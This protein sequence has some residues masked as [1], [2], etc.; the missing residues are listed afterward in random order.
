MS[1]AGVEQRSLRAGRL[2]PRSSTRLSANPPQRETTANSSPIP[3]EPLPP[4]MQ[5]NVSRMPV[6][7]MQKRAIAMPPLSVVTIQVLVSL[8]NTAV[9]T[10]VLNS[11]SRLK[12][13]RSAHG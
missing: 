8:L 9:F 2:R 5:P 3:G 10:R 1:H 7:M 4:S 6:A 13:K 11:I 12:S